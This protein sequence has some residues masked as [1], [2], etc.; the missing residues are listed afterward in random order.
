MHPIAEKNAN[1]MEVLTVKDLQEN[2]GIQL[3]R[4][5]R[6]KLFGT[7]MSV[8]EAKEIFDIVGGRPSVLSSLAKRKVRVGPRMK[9]SRH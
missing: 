4:Q 9:W 3:I 5:A 2:E 7:D 6:R 1:R 8:E